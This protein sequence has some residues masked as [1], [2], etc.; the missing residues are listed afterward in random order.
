MSKLP[1]DTSVRDIQGEDG[2]L[3]RFQG[4]VLL[5]VNTASEC[6]FTTQYAGLEAIY[7]RYRGDGLE[8][9]GFPCSQFGNQEPGSDSQIQN[10]APGPTKF[11]FPCF[12]RFRS[13]ATRHIRSI[14]R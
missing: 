2:N 13:T 7:Q 12:Q 8:I 3:E 11:R 10:S 5:V 14:K 4:K 6:G 1:Y 9:L